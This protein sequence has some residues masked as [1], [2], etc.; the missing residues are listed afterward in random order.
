ML[1][2]NI[3]VTRR[4]YSHNKSFH[5]DT[6]ADFGSFQPILCDYL[7]PGDTAAMRSFRQ[8]VRN[9]VMPSPTFGDIKCINKFTFVPVSDVFPAFEA[10]LSRQSIKTDIR[11]YIPT[12]VPTISST[13]LVLLLMRKS[14]S[15]CVV[16]DVVNKTETEKPGDPSH[17]GGNNFNLFT[18]NSSFTDVFSLFKSLIE[19]NLGVNSLTSAAILKNIQTVVSTLSPDS[20]DFRISN[21]D[22]NSAPAGARFL[23]VRLNAIGRRIYN[24]LRGLGYSLDPLNNNKVSFLPL[25]AYYKA[26]FDSY[27]PTREV[28]FQSTSCYKIIQLINSHGISYVFDSAN[29]PF[30]ELRDLLFKFF[31]EE[32]AYCYY[33]YPDDFVSSHMSKPLSNVLPSSSSLPT[34]GITPNVPTSASKLRNNTL[35]SITSDFADYASLSM[36]VRATKFLSKNSLIGARIHEYIKTHYGQ[37]V[38]NSV[39]AVSS[40]VANFITDIKLDDIY[41]TSDTLSSTS[42]QPL[43]SRGGV[44]SG[45][46]DDSFTYKASTFGFLIGMS[47]IYPDSYFC[48]GDDCLLYMTSRFGF[49]S[50]DF[51]AL[52]Y[53]LTPLACIYDNHGRV[54]GSSS[55]K[56]REI[57]NNASFGYVP[58]YSG[59]KTKRNLLNGDMA[60]LSTADS[61]RGYYLDRLIFEQ[62]DSFEPVTDGSSNG[63]LTYK[64]RLKKG[65]VPL[66]GVAWKQLLRYPQLGYFDRIFLNANVHL[67]PD[68]IYTDSSGHSHVDSSQPHDNNF[69]IQ[70]NCNYFVTNSLKPLSNSFDTFDEDV[71]NSTISVNNV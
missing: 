36:L 2:F 23:G 20:C 6:T 32:L 70:C 30:P 27:F 69:T 45:Y 54:Y 55:D 51:D 37:D 56:R 47:A 28:N 60:R 11:E 16:Y 18:I 58:R 38:Y 29:A 41:S 66:A 9:A 33:T 64:M 13:D 14:L 46:S 52:G 62:T 22:S 49:P 61:F 21:I 4:K 67:A 5:I 65:D 12:S 43:G 7:S 3:G 26:W 35:G 59:L 68:K 17:F 48:Q 19:G 8:L 50:A 10:L 71:D 42:G 40:N 25:L 1:N 24:I 53:E 34:D 15:S 63:K 44:G 57:G 31:D 39:F